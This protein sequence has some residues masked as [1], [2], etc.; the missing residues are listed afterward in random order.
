MTGFPQSTEFNRRIPKQVFYEKMSIPSSLKRFFID[1]IKTII[2]RNKIAST[3][4]NLATGATVNEIEVIEI[5]LTARQLDESVLRQIDTE[6]PYHILFLLEYD[7]LHQ[8][9]I[10]YKETTKVEKKAFHVGS[11]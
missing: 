10:A 9:W 7:G 6:I 8:A 4:T 5:H 11:Y 2:W 1:Q 3:T